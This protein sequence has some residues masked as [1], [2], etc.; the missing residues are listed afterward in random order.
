MIDAQLDGRDPADPGGRGEGARRLARDT[1]LRLWSEH[2][3]R[4]DADDADL[5]D[6][7]RG[8]VALA[9]G[10]AVLDRWYRAGGRGTRPPGHLRRHDPDRVGPWLKWPALAM[11]R[12]LLDPDGRPRAL[13]RANAI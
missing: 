5:V 13:R 4:A 7:D 12:G 3:G 9:E 8:I 6:P 2:L 1:R 11:Y 10:A